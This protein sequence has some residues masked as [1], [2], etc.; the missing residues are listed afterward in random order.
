VSTGWRVAFGGILALA[1]MVASILVYIVGA[2]APVWVTKFWHGAN[3]VWNHDNAALRCWSLWIFGGGETNGYEMKSRKAYADQK[4][5]IVIR[6]DRAK[7]CN[8]R[9]IL[10]RHLDLA[11]IDKC[12]VVTRPRVG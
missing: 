8:Q 4:V 3:P 12:R 11:A 9:R 1:M 7:D 2:L 5:T 6:L 10:R